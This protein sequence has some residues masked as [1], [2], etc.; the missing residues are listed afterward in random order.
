M[1]IRIAIVDDKR[2]MRT[3][4]S[5]QLSYYEELDVMLMA[6]DGNDFLTQMN[7][8]PTEKRPELVL[9]DIEMPN[10]DGIETVAIT[11]EIYPDV[12][13]LMLTVFDNDEKLFEAIRAGASGY[14]LKDEKPVVILKAITES[15]YEGGVPMSPRIAQK[16]L[17]LLRRTSLSVQEVKQDEQPQLDSVLSDREIEILQRIVDGLNYQQIG[18]RLFISPHTVRKHT[19]NIYNK[20]HV[21]NKA[22]A[23]KVAMHKKWFK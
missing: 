15:I 7:N 2:L 23:I 12:L 4:L 11:K 10:M 18:E 22:S 9:M 19:A 20:L 6:C 16:A 14:L 21:S 17:M 1:G 3:T 13:C 8:L 5:E